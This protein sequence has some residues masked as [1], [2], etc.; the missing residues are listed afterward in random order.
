MV[1]SPVKRPLGRTEGR[2]KR[3]GA[4]LGIPGQPSCA[5]NEC[6]VTMHAMHLFPCNEPP[7]PLL[8]L[9]PRG[10]GCPGCLGARSS[11]VSR[12]DI[13]GT[14]FRGARGYDGAPRILTHG[15]C[16]PSSVSL[17]LMAPPFK[18]EMTTSGKQEQAAN[19]KFAGAQ[20]SSP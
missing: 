2:V 16:L 10:R 4:L 12:R 18:G 15:G 5:S 14:R 6:H 11:R 7:L 20:S 1:L 9:A 13:H 17:S 3:F 19:S 8:D